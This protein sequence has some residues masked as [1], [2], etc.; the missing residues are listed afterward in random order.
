MKHLIAL[1]ALTAAFALTGAAARA[2]TGWFIFDV[3]YTIVAGPYADWPTCQKF[4]LLFER[5]APAGTLYTCSS[6]TY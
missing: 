6:R 5:N 1:A 4:A 2:D 3:H